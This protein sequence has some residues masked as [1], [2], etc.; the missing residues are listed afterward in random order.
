M[1]DRTDAHLRAVL[2]AIDDIT[3]EPPPLPTSPSRH[4]ARRQ[5]LLVAAGAF[6]VTLILVGAGVL[7]L[8]PGASGNGEVAATPSTQP[9]GVV[10]PQGPPRLILDFPETTITD[11]Y[12]IFDES[13]GFPVGMHTTYRMTLTDDTGGSGRE[14]LLR[15]QQPTATFP[16][17]DDL[18]ASAEG[19]DIVV[20]DG[21]EVTVYMIPDEAIAE[22]SYDLGILRWKE[23]PEYDAILIPWGMGPDEALTLMDGLKVISDD[24][25]DQLTSATVVT[26]TVVGSGDS[27]LISLMPRVAIDL[28]GFE[29]VDGSE[30]QDGPT[31]WHGE[32]LIQIGDTTGTITLDSDQTT[33]SQTFAN[34]D[35]PEQV[36]VAG[37]PGL[38]VRHDDG[39]IVEWELDDRITITIDGAGIDSLTLIE[40]IHYVDETT[41]R[42]LLSDTTG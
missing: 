24:E 1:N 13:T 41:W 23:T 34:Y 19:T 16:L 21:R 28:P 6:A 7:A 30:A 33:P 25:W 18:V 11:A 37:T 22:G 35:T 32:W 4:P 2:T 27:D 12:D 40:A 14:L 9:S 8:R 38:L 17:F 31:H 39:F 29:I 10:V 26:T 36:T 5:P 3:P 42:E 15:L 20:V